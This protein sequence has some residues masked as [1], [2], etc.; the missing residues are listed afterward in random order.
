MDTRPPFGVHRRPPVPKPSP[1][2]AK[3]APSC[4]SPT[5]P[6]DRTSSASPGTRPPVPPLPGTRRAAQSARPA[7]STSPSPSPREHAREK[8]VP[9]TPPSWTALVRLHG[10]KCA[11]PTYPPKGARG[12]SAAAAAAP[13]HPAASTLVCPRP[14]AALAL[15]DTP[16]QRTSPRGCVVKS[17]RGLERERAESAGAA[18]TAHE[19]HLVGTVLPRPAPESIEELVEFVSTGAVVAV[20]SGSHAGQAETITKALGR[21]VVVLPAAKVA[22]MAE[23]HARA[24]A[25]SSRRSVQSQTEAEGSKESPDG[26]SERSESE[27]DRDEYIEWLEGTLKEREAKYDDLLAHHKQAMAEMRELTQTLQKLFLQRG[28]S[29]VLPPGTDNASSP[30]AL[31]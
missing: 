25:D 15:A 4:S 3:R 23:Q 19:R 6:G 24:K 1:T 17:P 20:V 31:M 30:S 2:P 10:N 13:S 22:V 27:A 9:A 26:R 16:V 21:G 18:A 28:A 11:Y 14:V 8:E 12:A 5:P 7:G 29:Q